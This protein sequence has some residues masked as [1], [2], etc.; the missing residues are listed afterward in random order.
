MAV[1]QNLQRLPAAPSVAAPAD[2]LMGLSDEEWLA[3]KAWLMGTKAHRA[4]DYVPTDD[5]P[6]E[7]EPHHYILVLKSR[8]MAIAP[9]S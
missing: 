7:Y 6:D 3:L 4:L 9:R 2:A 8:A 5:K 1:S